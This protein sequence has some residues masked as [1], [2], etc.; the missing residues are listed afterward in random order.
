MTLD[1]ELFRR[2]MSAFPTGVTVVTTV[3]AD[4]EPKGLTLQAFLAV[5]TEPPLLL[6]SLD[7]T[8]R[9]LDAVQAHGA[10]VVN[11]IAAGREHLSNTFASKAEEKFAHVNWRPSKIARGSPVFAEDSVAYVECIITQRIAAGDHFLFLASVEGGE[12]YDR[13]PL[14]YFRRSYSSWSSDKVASAPP[15]HD[16]WPS[17]GDW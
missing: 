6:I 15:A 2:L 4:G 17:Y 13:M 9:T 8:S 7:R 16:D 11:F 14:M 1:R 10:F 12:S 5:S 3:G